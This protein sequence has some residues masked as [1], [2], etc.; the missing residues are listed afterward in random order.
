MRFGLEVQKEVLSYWL[1]MILPQLLRHF[2]RHR[3]DEVFYQMQAEDAIRWLTANRVIAAPG[4][5]ALDLGCGHGVF[6]MALARQG[7]TVTFADAENLLRPNARTMPFRTIDLDR[8]S[9]S[10][11]GHY[12]LVVCSNVL[13]HLAKP[14]RLL[15]EASTL[16]QPG[17]RFFLSWTNWLSPW[18]GHEFSPL[19][20]LGPNWG[21]QLYDRMTGDPKRR[22]HRPFVNLFPTYIGEV[23]RTIRKEQR[24]ELE[25]MAPRYYTEF[26]FILQLPVVREF[27]AWNCALLL[28][29]R[30]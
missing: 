14:N 1:F 28:R 8:D 3:D 10:S 17:G 12:D 21:P 18:G 16:L 11:L 9:V 30:A 25:A 29:A 23:L 20:Y 24:L 2:L 7:W 22:F 13:E 4:R 6:G 27:L 19:H 5:T 15:S 26:G